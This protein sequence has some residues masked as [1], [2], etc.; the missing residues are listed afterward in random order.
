MATKKKVKKSKVVKVKM[1]K[2]SDLPSILEQ[3]SNLPGVDPKDDDIEDI[4]RELS[5]M[6]GFSSFSIPRK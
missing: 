2:V 5:A 6:G 3:A 1:I 4:L